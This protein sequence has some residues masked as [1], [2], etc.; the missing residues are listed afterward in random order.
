[1]CFVFSYIISL[2][3][4]G[5]TCFPWNYTELFLFS[6]GHFFSQEGYTEPKGL[7]SK[8]AFPGHIGL[9]KLSGSKTQ[10]EI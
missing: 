3:K 8:P 10:C 4:R 7:L 1:M 2:L 9:T 5:N 6:L